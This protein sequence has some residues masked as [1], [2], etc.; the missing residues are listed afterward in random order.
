M[1]RA[2][3]VVVLTA[4]WSLVGIAGAL[5]A[6]AHAPLHCE[7]LKGILHATP[8]LSDIPTDQ[9]LTLAARVSGCAWAGGSGIVVATTTAAQA[10]CA[11]LTSELFSTTATFL[12]ADHSASTV[13][14]RFRSAPG[15]PNR[16]DLAGTVI[17]GNAAG[18]RIRS[19]L[20]LRATSSRTIRQSPHHQRVPPT[21]QIESGPLSTNGAGC[22]AVAP[23]TK[24]N[25]A[26][27]QSLQF[28]ADR[29][30][31]VK[32][33]ARHRKGRSS[34]QTANQ[35]SRVRPSIH[36]ASSTSTT[37]GR[38]NPSAPSRGRHRTDRITVTARPNMQTGPNGNGLPGML[39]PASLLFGAFLATSA[40]LFVAL[41]KPAWFARLL[42]RASRSHR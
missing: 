41:L 18:D 14:L 29:P 20:H 4:L 2:R 22:A 33:A 13:S 24:I 37:V 42:R 12:W 9:T 34:K 26:S 15:S 11:S 30:D 3:L 8:G 10:T 25:V 38:L 36:P 28:S 31:S 23:L 32:K 5:P 39:E 7:S 19:G 17:A 35:T 1:H 6:H 21:Q 27:S 40:G 16:L